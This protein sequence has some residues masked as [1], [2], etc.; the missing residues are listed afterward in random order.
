MKTEAPHFS[1]PKRDRYFAD[2]KRLGHAPEA[3]YM[4]APFDWTENQGDLAPVVRKINTA[5]FI[6]LMMMV[7]FV[8]GVVSCAWMAGVL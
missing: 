3:P 1:Y 8:A 4:D 7:G 2:P 6:G 5:L